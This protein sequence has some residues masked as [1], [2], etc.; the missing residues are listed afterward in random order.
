MCEKAE[1]AK[2]DLQGHVIVVGVASGP[3]AGGMLATWLFQKE[4]DLEQWHHIE[5]VGS[6]SPSSLMNV[7]EG[8]KKRG[9][10]F[11]SQFKGRIADMHNLC[12]AIAELGLRTMFMH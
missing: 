10:K 6:R 11:S 4:E 7:I 8:W 5:S 9:A 1:M 2:Q 12:G 3:T